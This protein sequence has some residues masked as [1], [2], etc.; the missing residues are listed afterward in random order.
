[1]ACSWFLGVGAS[2]PHCPHW[3]SG[4]LSCGGENAVLSFLG[5]V[6]SE[7][8]LVASF[9]VWLSGGCCCDVLRESRGL[10]GEDNVVVRRSVLRV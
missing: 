6:E 8:E 9:L 1:M 4:G 7:V 2:G 10:V 5:E 3:K